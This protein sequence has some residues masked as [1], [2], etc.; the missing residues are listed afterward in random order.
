MIMLE[1]FKPVLFHPILYGGGGSHA[2]ESH[3]FKGGQYQESQKDATFEFSS[4]ALSLPVNAHCII[5]YCIDRSTG[6]C[7]HKGSYTC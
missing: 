2:H 3:F 6:W 1:Y 4:A 5:F 7:K